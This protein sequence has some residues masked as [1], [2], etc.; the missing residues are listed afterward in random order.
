MTPVAGWS[1]PLIYGAPKRTMAAQNRLH[2]QS[3]RMS[4]ARVG[5]DVRLFL[6]YDHGLFC[7][8]LAEPSNAQVLHG[9]A[10]H[11]RH[12]DRSSRTAAVVAEQAP[13]E[14][15]ECRAEEQGRKRARAE[16]SPRTAW[17]R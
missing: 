9:M 8:D 5:D 1:L 3:P 4:L 14:V 2:P 15:A 10:P 7:S 11:D 16:G 13:Q 6:R 12:Q 17:V